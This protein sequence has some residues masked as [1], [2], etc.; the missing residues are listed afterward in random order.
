MYIHKCMVRG[1]SRRADLEFWE[2]GPH[3]LLRHAR[4]VLVAA[5]G[6]ALGGHAIEFTTVVDVLT[7]LVHRTTHT[8][9]H[10][11]TRTH[12]CT[13]ELVASA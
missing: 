6:H 3:V 1:N 2:V 12:T 4:A 13:H 8:H 5:L 9:A 7:L 11:H 10:A